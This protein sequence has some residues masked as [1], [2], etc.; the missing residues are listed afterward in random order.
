M[1]DTVFR[2]PIFQR[3]LIAY[4]DDI[5]LWGRTKEECENR[6][7]VVLGLLAENNLFLKPSKCVF[8][9]QEV[10]YLGH[11]IRPGKLAVDPKKTIRISRLAYPQKEKGSSEIPWVRQL[12]LE[13]YPR[14]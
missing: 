9:S 12:L 1:M 8:L 10:E 4:I 2:D 11:I 14:F 13:V 7:K 3:W 6:A 5:L